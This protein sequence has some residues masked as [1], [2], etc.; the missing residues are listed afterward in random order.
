MAVDEP[1]DERRVAALGGEK[2]RGELVAVTLHAPVNKG[3]QAGKV[4]AASVYADHVGGSG[5]QPE[6][7]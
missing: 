4:G 1:A 6:R 3:R 5:E 7:I 2:G